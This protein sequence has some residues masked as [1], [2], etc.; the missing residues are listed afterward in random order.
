MSG[1]GSVSELSIDFRLET[2]ARSS[3]KR[4]A[5]KPKLGLRTQSP[6]NAADQSDYHRNYKQKQ[7]MNGAQ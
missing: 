4:T 2:I 7:Q 1:E 3:S 6:E 5:M